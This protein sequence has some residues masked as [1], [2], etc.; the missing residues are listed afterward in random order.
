MF[1]DPFAHL[2]R[3]VQAGKIEITLFELLHDS[4][5]MQVV[6][7]T[8]PIIAHQFVQACFPRVPKWRM[9]DVVHQRQRFRE[10]RVQT[11]SLRDG[12]RN[13]SHFDGVRQPIAEMIGVAGRKDL[14]FSLQAPKCARVDHAIAIPR[15]FV[16][17][18][19][20]RLW[21]APSSRTVHV[22]AY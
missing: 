18:G 8:V 5:R 14:R 12:A 16:P 13:L 2:K 11:E 6:I 21:P 3:Q 10:F 22:H 19:M 17:I 15:I 4:Q 1:N 20:F 7:E 9:P